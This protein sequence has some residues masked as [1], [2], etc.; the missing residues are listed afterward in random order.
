MLLYYPKLSHQHFQKYIL[1]N[2]SSSRATT[3][4]MLIGSNLAATQQWRWHVSLAANFYV[5]RFEVWE[6]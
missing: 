1:E 6:L 2:T 5:T 4:T 3:T